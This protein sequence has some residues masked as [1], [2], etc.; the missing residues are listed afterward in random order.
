MQLDR[1]FQGFL[2]VLLTLSPGFTPAR[3]PFSP[4]VA[5]SADLPGERTDVPPGYHTVEEIMELAD[6]LETSFPAICR[7]VV[8]G[9]SLGGRELAALMIS[10]S[11]HIEEREPAVMFDGGCHGNEVGGPEN[12]IRFARD[13]CLGYGSDPIIT[14][15][16]NTR[17]IW[18][19]LMVNPDGR[20]VMSRFNG[21]GVDLNRDYGYM[22]DAS[23]GSPGAFSQPE[24]RGVRKCLDT[25]A[26]SIYISYHSG[27]EQ[28]AYPWA[29]REEDA[30]DK[31]H[32]RNLAQAYSDSSLYPALPFGQSWSIMYQVN[33]MSV[34]YAYGS[35][36]VACMTVELS[37]DHAPADPQYYYLVNYP[38]MLEMVR[39]CGWGLR[40]VVT[41]SVTGLAVN[42]AVRI[43]ELF[44]SYANP[45]TGT[46]HRYLLPGSYFVSVSAPGYKTREGILAYVPPG[47]HGS[48]S[49]VL[50]PDTMIAGHRVSSCR[51]P[52]NNPGDEGYTPAAL[53]APDSLGY[54]LGKDGWIVIDL[55]NPMNLN[56]WET[57]TVYEAGDPD[58][59]FEC[60]VSSS[61][62]GP[63]ISLGTG[64]GTTGF[65]PGVNPGIRFVMIRDDGDGVSMESDAGFDLD[66][67]LVYPGL[68]T[69]KS[70]PGP[71]FVY[72][73][74]PNPSPDRFKVVFPDPESGTVTVF[75]PAGR[76]ILERSCEAGGGIIDLSFYPDGCYYGVIRAGTGTAVVKLVK[77]K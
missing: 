15:L 23:G 67:I 14:E 27:L 44:P 4:V 33:G 74:I 47:G 19:Y 58:E 3:D 51:I 59:G 56:G 61:P 57:L 43:G 55:G 35:G 13:L 41:D 29:Y 26:C 8:F 1:I 21:A 62:D 63:W 31:P 65:N 7:K 6:S 30:P 16:V 72:R 52:G 49:V 5:S 37:P 12:L 20:E 54:S 39:R 28:A 66:G 11:V 18:L 76:R 36:G 48:I 22:W 69:G 71:T 46:F 60:L 25:S 24:S 68:F 10:D 64:T 50:A 38:A 17:V 45:V 34:D 73:V 70:E 77:L 42:A 53:L 2:F 75:D 32:L 9:T 40:G